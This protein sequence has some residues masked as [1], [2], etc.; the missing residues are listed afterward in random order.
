MADLP[1]WAAEYIGL[2]Y[3]ER[4]RTRAGLDCWG[5][6]RLV[7]AERFGIVLPAFD[8]LGYRD[9]GADDSLLARARALAAYM[10]E[11]MQPWDR[12]PVKSDER[13]TWMALREGDA[14]H[15]KTAGQPIHCGV[16][17]AAPWFLHIEE[18]IDSCVEDWTA[19]RTARRVAGFYR[20]RGSPPHNG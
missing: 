2:P 10:A 17:V 7:T 19:I 16:V 13:A 20:W 5:L 9:F 4:G 6:L 15:L 3:A 18:G 11:H 12:L 8:G 1:S 14:I